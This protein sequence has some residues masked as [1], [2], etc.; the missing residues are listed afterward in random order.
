MAEE[1]TAMPKPWETSR[2][3]VL[4][5]DGLPRP[6]PDLVAWNCWMDRTGREMA[7]TD[8]AVGR[9]LARTSI[10]DGVHVSTVFVGL[11]DVMILVFGGPPVLFETMIRGGPHDCRQWR[12]STRDQALHGHTV[13][14]EAL[15]YGRDLDAVDVYG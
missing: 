12:Y 14:V 8:A 11:A 7:A 5:A 4:D 1:G 15:L 3:Y 9:R 2:H 6:E 10:G 13:V